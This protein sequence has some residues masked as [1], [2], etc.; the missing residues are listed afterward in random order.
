MSG[1]LGSFIPSISSTLLL[2][3]SGA[4]VAA[5][6]LFPP[7]SADVEAFTTMSGLNWSMILDELLA[8]GSAVQDGAENRT[9]LSKNP[10]R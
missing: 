3:T 4:G 5:R 6:V 8:R 9:Y 10:K 2:W 7:G 1:L